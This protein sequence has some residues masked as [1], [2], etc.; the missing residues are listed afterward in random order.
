MRLV[1]E[2]AAHMAG[3]ETQVWSTGLFHEVVV[4]LVQAEDGE[5]VRAEFMRK[6]AAQYHDVAVY[7]VMRIAYAL[8]HSEL[9]YRAAI[10][11]NARCDRNYLST[12]R[13][14]HEIDSVIAMLTD[15]GGPP[16]QDATFD[17]FYAATSKPNSKKKTTGPFT[18]PLSFKKKVQDAWLGV[19]RHPHDTP[20][21]K[22]LLRIMSR[23]IAPYFVKP[24]LL[25][26]FLTDTYNHNEGGLPLLALSGL[27]YLIQARNLDY[28]HF[29]TK[30]YSLL[31]AGL[32]HSKHRS[33]SL[34]LFA[35]F[36]ASTHLPAALVASFIKRLARLALFAPPAAVVVV[37]PFVYNL[38]VAHP[39]CTFLLHREIPTTTTS[40][41]PHAHSPDHAFPDPFDPSEP[42]PSLTHALDSSLWELHSLHAHY[43]PNVAAI[44]RILSEQF[45][46][47]SY[48][49]EDF[50]DHSYQGLLEAE[51]GRGGGGGGEEKPFRKTPVVEFQIPKRIF[52]DRLLREEDGGGGVDTESN[53]A[54]RELWEF[55]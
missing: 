6:F 17:S 50:L 52:T 19:L 18:S 55:S 9:S 21:R 32:L 33:R 35:T 47:S 23:N 46:K 51:L 4:A 11:A 41:N 16:A 30:L 45:T 24:E 54:I 28:P 29:Y 44:A 5:E 43:H 7:L 1:K 42:D 53:A 31:D 39:A 48:N 49:L 13:P 34:R 10:D 25:M 22:A 36:L 8:S 15:L 37:V 38:L 27:F 3:S 14:S 26:D 20:R 2:Q 12:E 40:S